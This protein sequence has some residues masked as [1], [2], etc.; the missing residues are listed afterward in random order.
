MRIVK[1]G[2]M[3]LGRLVKKSKIIIP[4]PEK[5][6]IKKLRKKF[7]TKHITPSYLRVEVPT[8]NTRSDYIFDITE[9]GR[10]TRTEK[11][12][13]R[14]DVFIVQDMGLFLMRRNPNTVGADYLETYPNP[15]R[16][17]LAGVDVSHLH[18]F[19]NGYLRIRVNNRVWYDAFDS[20][21][22]LYI[23]ETQQ[24]FGGNYAQQ[25]PEFGFVEV[26]PELKLFGN[27][28]NEIVL[29]VPTFQGLQV[30]STAQDKVYLVFYVR[31]LLASGA[32]LDMARD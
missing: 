21:R 5:A 6:L 32:A 16:F 12:L 2:G 1:R 25:L 28:K 7:G 14:N 13:N 24:T 22:F 17:D 18:I 27:A 3:R 31:G 19:Y 11:K 29:S 20:R 4:D 10:E 15:V 9:T 8:S 23:P 30:E 26:K